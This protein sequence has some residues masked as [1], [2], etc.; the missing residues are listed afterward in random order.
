[1]RVLAKILA[2]IL[3][4]LAAPAT[5]QI[6][7]NEVQSANHQ[8]LIE[9]DGEAHD[10]IEIANQGAQAVNLSGWGLSDKSNAPHKWIFGDVLLSPG[11]HLVV[12]ASGEDLG[13]GLRWNT[14]I[15][16]G[17]LWSYHAGPSAPPEAWSSPGFDDSGWAQGPS[18]F[19]YGY[20]NLGSIIQTNTI[21]TRRVFTIS[22]AELDD[23]IQAW[24][25]A[26]ATLGAEAVDTNLPIAETLQRARD[27]VAEAESALGD[28]QCRRADRAI[29]EMREI[30][31]QLRRR[32]L[33]PLHECNQRREAQRRPPRTLE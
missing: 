2:A 23:A 5:A 31:P 29:V 21:Y 16:D 20:P 14:I 12:R 13:Q 19:G 25:V 15:D 10:W 27:L 28:N 32:F 6:V 4:P 30:S 24:E 7:L 3:C 8:T 11:G 33:G 1:M 26:R 9:V 17:A 22:E 18:G